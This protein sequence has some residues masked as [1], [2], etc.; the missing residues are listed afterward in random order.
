MRK[1]ENST[2]PDSQE[3]PREVLGRVSRWKRDRREI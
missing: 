2:D 1:T 3:I